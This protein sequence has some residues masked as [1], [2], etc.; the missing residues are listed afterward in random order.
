M[1][2][3]LISSSTDTEDVHTLLSG[4]LPSNRYYRINP[5]LPRTIAIDDTNE[6]TLQELRELGKNAVNELLSTTTTITSSASSNP[7]NSRFQN[8]L[9]SL[10][11]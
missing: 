7:T 8:L 6:S 5:F 1:L 9:A 10:T 2:D 4:L 3:H 11:K